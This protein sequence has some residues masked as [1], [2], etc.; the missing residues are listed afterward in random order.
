MD[1]LDGFVSH[2]RDSSGLECDAVVHLRDGTYGLVE[3]KLGGDDLIEEGA[4][5]LKSLRDAIDTDKMGS[6]AFCMVL[7]GVGEYSYLREDGIFVV[8]ICALGV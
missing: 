2:Y 1:E 4:S 7:V 3:V 5:S 6:P 8:P